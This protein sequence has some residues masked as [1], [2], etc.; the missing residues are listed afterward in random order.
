MKSLLRKSETTQGVAVK[1][2]VQSAPIEIPLPNGQTGHLKVDVAIVARDRVLIAGWCLGGIDLTICVQGKAVETKQLAF[3]RP[4][5]A[6]HFKLEEPDRVGFVLVAQCD[7]AALE[8]VALASVLS[9]GDDWSLRPIK[10]SSASE[11]SDGDIA[12]L[13]P[14]RSLLAHQF[15]PLSRDWLKAVALPSAPAQGSA[16]GYLEG[17]VQASGTSHGVA[18]G[19]AVVEEGG[20]LWLEDE[21]GNGYP[22]EGASWRTRP[23]VYRAVGADLG[24]KALESGFSVRFE[25]PQP[26][27]RL[28]L[29]ALTSKG[30]HLLSEVDCAAQSSDPVDFA[31]WLFGIHVPDGQLDTHTDIVDGPILEA[32][33]ARSRNVQDGLRVVTRVVGELPQRPVASIIVPLYGRDDFVESQMLEWARDPWIQANAELIYVLDDPGLADP[34]RTKAE[35]LHRLYGVPFRWVWGNANRGFSGANNLGAQ[36]AQGDHLLFLN[37]DVF[38]QRPGWL[39]QMLEVLEQRSDVGAVGPRLT[40]ADGGIQ[41]AGMRFSWLSDY[42]VWINQHPLVGLDT[43]LDPAR[44]VTLVP[45]VTGACLLMRKKD[46]EDIGG[47]DTGY[48]IGDF[49]DSDICLKLRER[50]LGIAYL[51]EVQLTHLERQSMTAVGTGGFRMRVT[52]WNALRHQRRWRPLIERGLEVAQ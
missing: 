36:F 32:L 31:H 47:W 1:S 38:P 16:A 45:A 17:A 39:A 12:M 7:S 5:V 21:H 9:G 46:F 20:L 14:G 40:F 28:K 37:S 49:E 13:G 29:K 19:W 48:L 51:P 27:S 10:L 52:L 22:L 25:S 24:S 3:S 18:V 41:H 11:L 50:G 43:R 6:Q 35:E 42:D 26:V 30:V 33:I 44:G 23:D 4:D 8:S 34:F 15:A 2:T